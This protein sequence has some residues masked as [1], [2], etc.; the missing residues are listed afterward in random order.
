MNLNL[1]H[2]KIHCRIMQGDDRHIIIFAYPDARI[3]VRRKK[4]VV[5]FSVPKPSIPRERRNNN[6][7]TAKRANLSDI[8]FIK[9]SVAAVRRQ[10]GKFLVVVPKLKK[11]DIVFAHAVMQNIIMSFRAETFKR[12][13]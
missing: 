12:K 2:Y 11:H 7:N 10:V 1:M 13:S 9:L 6:R 8:Y 5:R 4:I 3:V